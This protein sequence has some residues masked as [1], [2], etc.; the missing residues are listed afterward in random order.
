MEDSQYTLETLYQVWDDKTGERI[1]IGPDRDGL[2]LFEIRGCS[3]EG[4]PY[5]RIVCNREQLEKLQ[6]AINLVLNS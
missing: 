5:A 4:K 6:A 3:H 1:E 2:D